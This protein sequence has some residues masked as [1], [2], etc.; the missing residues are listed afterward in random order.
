MA[1]PQCVFEAMDR[2]GEGPCWHPGEL[3]LYWTD[4][5]SKTI[6]RWDPRTGDH[7]GWPMPEMVTAISV[8]RSG[9]LIVA[10]HR[11]I[12]FFD[13]RTGTG[14][15]FVEPER[16]K[17]QN[18][19]ND[20]KCDRQGRFWYGTMMN[21]FAEDMSEM[22]ITANTGGLYRI[23]GDGSVT[24]FEQGLGIANTFAWAPDERTMYFADTLDAIYAYDFDAPSGMISNRRIFANA[25]TGTYGLPDGSTIDAEGF[26]W[27]ARWDGGCIIRWAP[28]GTIDR[29]VEFPCRR[30]TSC[31]FGGADLDTL[32]VTTVRY[33]LS[34]AELSEQP[35]A[36]SIFACDP[37]V[38]GLPDGQFAG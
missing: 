27:N 17:P 6:K 10:S 18:R 16:D 22:P 25:D 15:R 20:G 24:V 7:M 14:T 37:R 35:L 38:K 33:G 1:Q 23:D 3:A 9:G 8:R 21:N 32:Y 2:L 36:G 34:D 26:L 19:S 12:D 31:I 28:D 4:V 5:P 29:I 13:P 30:V 11:G